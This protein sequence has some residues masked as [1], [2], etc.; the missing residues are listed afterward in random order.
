MSGS[1]MCM[2]ED[3]KG[4]CGWLI[5]R[6]LLEDLAQD[7]LIEAWHCLRHYNGRCRFFVWLCAILLNRHRNTFRRKWLVPLSSLAPAGEGK[8]Q[9]SLE[10]PADPQASPD[11]TVQHREQA[12]LVRACLQALSPK[13]R[14]VIHL[15][16]YM[17]DSLED[18][19]SALG[20]SVGTVKSRLFHALERPGEMGRD[21][22]WSKSG[23]AAG[24]ACAWRHRDIA[25]ATG[26]RFVA[27]PPGQARGDGRLAGVGVERSSRSAAHS[28][29]LSISGQP[30]PGRIGC[31]HDLAGQP[32]PARR[33]R[34]HDA[35]TSFHRRLRLSRVNQ[36]TGGFWRRLIAFWASGVARQTSTLAGPHLPPD[37]TSLN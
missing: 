10:N 1:A 14:Q 6:G 15:R 32:E 20:C 12:T 16:F 36:A 22:L 34:S 37:P 28:R 19:A 3:C 26:P 4:R 27:P 25:G 33:R 2:K 17:D 7:T 29:Q 30:F 13:H 23:L 35:P 31:P 5:S 21:I 11:E 8:P 18:I 9:E 24:P